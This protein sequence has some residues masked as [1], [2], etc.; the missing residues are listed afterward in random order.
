[1]LI[2]ITNYKR[3][4]YDYGTE[5]IHLILGKEGYILYCC[6]GSVKKVL[7]NPKHHIS[8]FICWQFLVSLT[9]LYLQRLIEI[10][11]L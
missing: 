6:F 1:M 4:K 3:S 8:C 10:Q 9:F 5:G 7:I 11:C 2:I